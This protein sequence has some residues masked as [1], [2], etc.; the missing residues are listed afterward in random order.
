MIRFLQY[1]WAAPV[2]LL[3]L[4]LA[5]VWRGS[6]LW[7]KGVLE[8]YVGQAMWPRWAGGITLGWVILYRNVMPSDKLQIHEREHVR[9]CMVLGP[10]SLLLYPLASLC[11]WVSGGDYYRD[12]AFEVRARRVA[13]QTV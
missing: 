7:H 13:K 12:N 6:P 10:L 2:S 11:A 5:V 1:I 3:G 4:L 9:Q 8:V